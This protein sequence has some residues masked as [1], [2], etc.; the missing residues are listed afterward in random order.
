M[1]MMMMMMMFSQFIDSNHTLIQVVAWVRIPKL[2]I[3]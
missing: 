2:F 3:E 1:M